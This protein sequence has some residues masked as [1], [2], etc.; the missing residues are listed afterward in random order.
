MKKY[1]ILFLFLWLVGFSSGFAEIKLIEKD[2]YRFT[3]SPY[4]RTS[5]FAFGN[6][7][8][9]DSHRN[10][11]FSYMAFY[12]GLDFDLAFKDEG[13]EF[14]ASFERNGP[15]YYDAP[16]WIDGA[17]QTSVA[18][19]ER[20]KGTDWLPT[21]NEYWMDIPLPLGSL[22]FKGGL[23][24]HSFGNGYAVGMGYYENYGL[25]FYSSNETFSYGVYYFKPDLS[26]KIILGPTIQQEREQEIDYQP[27][28][29][30]FFGADI[31]WLLGSNRFQPYIGFLVDETSQDKRDNGFETPTSNDILGTLG[32]AWNCD[33]EKLSLSAELARNFGSAQSL[34]S[35]LKDVEHKGYLFFAGASYNLGKVVPNAKF[36]LASGNQVTLEDVENDLEKIP[37]GSNRAFSVLSPFNY[38][39][40]DSVYPSSD[41]KPFVAMGNGYGLNYGVD[42]P[43]TSL[44]T[45]MYENLIMPSFGLDVEVTEKLAISVSWWYMASMEKGVGQYEGSA[46]Y[47]SRDLGHEIDLFIEYDLL[48]WLTLELDFGYFLKLVLYW[49]MVFV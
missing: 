1:L 13:P 48:E 41:V 27:N 43:T 21:L 37:G 8:Y 28:A 16:L 34:D 10:D 39:L 46:K 29:A 20:Y 49:F 24:N 12:Y 47:L 15:W 42:R 18:P 40:A 2:Q 14:F 38:N 32:V 19:I 23:L 26:H 7:L 4:A 36:F 22:R 11:S 25:G 17:L 6:N 30:N 33:L 35:G 5:Y 44:D 45:V 9:L 3:F 31:S